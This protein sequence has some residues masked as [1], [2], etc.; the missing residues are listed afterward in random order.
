MD[1]CRNDA[2]RVYNWTCCK[3]GWSFHDKERGFFRT[4][5][6]VDDIT[7][8]EACADTCVR[9]GA[10][11]SWTGGEPKAKVLNDTERAQEERLQNAIS[12]AKLNARL[13]QLK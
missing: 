1:I 11:Q 8:C 3:C 13:N 10:V 6:L 12:M 9:Q 7:M 2:P 5:I 4:C